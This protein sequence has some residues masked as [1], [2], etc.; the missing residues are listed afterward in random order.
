MD[1][2]QRIIQGNRLTLSQLA[3]T[4]RG[5]YARPMGGEFEITMRDAKDPRIVLDQIKQK[6]IVTRFARVCMPTLWGWMS[7]TNVSVI[8]FCEEA[9]VASEWLGSIKSKLTLS[10][11]T[12]MQLPIPS[13][14]GLVWTYSASYGAPAAD[15]TFQT[16]FIGL[17]DGN[18]YGT[19]SSGTTTWWTHGGIQ[20]YTVLTTPRTQLTS[21][22]L[23]ITYRI[24]FAE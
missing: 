5:P 20:A 19:T 22:L 24:T 9:N 8:G 12:I 15:R 13:K 18:L 17:A 6:N 7:N 10:P 4:A 23:D 1:L 21:S 3:R 11:T 14:S 16:V 2:G